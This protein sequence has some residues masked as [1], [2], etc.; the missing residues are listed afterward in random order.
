[1]SFCSNGRRM[2]TD[3]DLELV[4]TWSSRMPMICS[5]RRSLRCMCVYDSIICPYAGSPLIAIRPHLRSNAV[6]SPQNLSLN[7]PSCLPC[8]AKKTPP[9]PPV[10]EMVRAFSRLTLTCW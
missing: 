8:E 1:M 3:V 10:S 5:A 2:V 6:L 7:P 9:L 4:N